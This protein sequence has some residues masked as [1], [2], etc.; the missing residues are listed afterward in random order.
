M[1]ECLANKRRHEL[2][3]LKEARPKQRPRIHQLTELALA[4]AAAESELSLAYASGSQRGRLPP[5]VELLL[6]LSSG[7]SKESSDMPPAPASPLCELWWAGRGA[8]SRSPSPRPRR[9]EPLGE[10]PC[11]LP[12]PTMALAVARANMPE[13]PTVSPALVHRHGKVL[14]AIPDHTA[15]RRERVLMVHSLPE[16]AQPRHRRSKI[17]NVSTSTGLRVE[18]AC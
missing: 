6:G 8:P 10:V 13:I 15:H 9:L 3:G 11:G 16:L 17:F 1:F 7:P 12:S 4:D 18:S 2:L 14:L 5:L